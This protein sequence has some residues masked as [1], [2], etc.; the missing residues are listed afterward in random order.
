MPCRDDG[1]P[2]DND[3]ETTARSRDVTF[4]Q[5]QNKID[6]L[7]RMLCD[8]LGKWTNQAGK[9]FS[10]TQETKEWWR[11]HQAMDRQRLEREN[12]EAQEKQILRDA[13]GKL[14]PEELAI[15]RKSFG[16]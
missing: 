2:C 3:A 13:V 15:L 6:K 1:Y 9:E 8:V 11:E 16:K 12:R 4:K 10:L 14:S 7:T 5:M